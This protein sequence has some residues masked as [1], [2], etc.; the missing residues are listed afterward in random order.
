MNAHIPELEKNPA[1]RFLPE[2]AI[3]SLDSDGARRVKQAHAISKDGSEITIEAETFVL[4]A[5]AVENAAIILRSSG[6]KQHPLVG[7]YLFD[8]PVFLLTAKIRQD[9]FPN[10]GY[11]IS[12]ALCHHFV[13]G[14]AV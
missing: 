10:Y 4:A 1:I 12:T 9:G 2:T 5:N 11:S 13:D 6:V 3:V 14:A 8:H 7:K